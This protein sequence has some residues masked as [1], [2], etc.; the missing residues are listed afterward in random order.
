MALVGLLS[1]GHVSH[2]VS[3]NV[4]GLHLRSGVPRERLSELHGDVFM[5]ACEQCGTEYFRPF[6]EMPTV[7]FRLTGRTCTAPV[8]DVDAAANGGCSGGGGGSDGGSG[9]GGGGGSGG[10][11]GGGDGGASVCGGRLRDKVLDWDDALP[12][13]DAASADAASDAAALALVVG[14]SMQMTAARGFALRTTR[15]PGG[16]LAVAN[17]SRTWGDKHARLV[18]RAPADALFAGLCAALRVPIP[19]YVR[20]AGVAVGA[21][22]QPAGPGGGRTLRV[23][24]AGVLPPPDDGLPFCRLAVLRWTAPPAGGGG[25]GGGGDELAVADTDAARGWA[26]DLVGAPPGGGVSGSRVHVTLHLDHSVCGRP[27]VAPTTATVSQAVVPEAEG[28]DAPGVAIDAG[29]ARPPPT[30][31]VH[32]VVLARVN[33]TAAAAGLVASAAAAAAAVKVPVDVEAA[34]V[35]VFFHRLGAASPGRCVC[36]LCGEAVGHGRKRAHLLVCARVAVGGAAQ[37]EA[38]EED[39]EEA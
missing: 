30:T 23:A 13:G 37:P 35:A 7:G 39:G 10:G 4:D 16:A 5:E 8:V 9:G 25:A 31:V 15:R 33:Y 11:G 3:Q 1:A 21:T 38:K 2:V 17:L 32:D 26:V 19:P 28:R 22:P 24:L 34:D 20:R 6:S 14:S 29:A 27:G 12:E 36:V 18:V